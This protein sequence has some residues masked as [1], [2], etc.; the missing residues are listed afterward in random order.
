MYSLVFEHILVMLSGPGAMRVIV[1]PAVAVVLGILH[2]L[3]D[4]RMGR[5]P[6]WA[7]F[8]HATGEERWQCLRQA[9]HDIRIPLT[10]AVLAS[11]TFQYLIRSRIV[12]GYAFLFALIFVALP[13]FLARGLANPKRREKESDA[14]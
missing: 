2:G 3:R 10:I 9:V 11:V 12:L 14:T 5:R 4:H 1:Q 13:Y 6:Y 7:E 8:I